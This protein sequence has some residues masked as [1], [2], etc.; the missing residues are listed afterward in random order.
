VSDGDDDIQALLA[1]AAHAR[2]HAARL[3]DDEARHALNLYARELE[4]EAAKL[5][6][7]RE[8][9]VATL[10]EQAAEA[11]RGEPQLGPELAAAMKPPVP[12]PENDK[13]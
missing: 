7:E 11:P 4:A 1:K 3:M 12:P 6:A 2:G 10:P 13:S 5:R 8:Q 9:P